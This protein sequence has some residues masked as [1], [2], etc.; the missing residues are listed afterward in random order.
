M[1]T[2]KYIVLVVGAVVKSAALTAVVGA[3]ATVAEVKEMM[4]TG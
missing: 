2:L 1:H 4:V 3:E